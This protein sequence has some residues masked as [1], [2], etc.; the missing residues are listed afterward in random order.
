MHGVY[1]W[2]EAAFSRTEYTGMNVCVNIVYAFTFG[3][4]SNYELSHKGDCTNITPN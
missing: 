4:H 2:A 1:V 3:I